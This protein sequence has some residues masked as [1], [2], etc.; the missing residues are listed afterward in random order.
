MLAQLHRHT[1]CQVNHRRLGRAVDHGA[2]ISGQIR[3]NGAVVDDRARRLRFHD[4]RGVLHAEHHGAHKQRHRGVKAFHR[5]ALDAAGRG[6]AAGIVEQHVEPAVAVEHMA[7]GALPVR[8][9]RCVGRHIA[10]VRTQPCRYRV[11][12]WPAP[13]CKD[14]AG[15]F[16]D[17]E[18]RSALADAAGRSGDESDLAVKH[19]HGPILTA[20]DRRAP[21]AK[22][23]RAK[24][25]KPLSGS[26]PM[27]S[28]ILRIEIII[29]HRL[30]CATM[31]LD[32]HDQRPQQCW[33]CDTLSESNPVPIRSCYCR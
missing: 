1:P 2:R 7:H 32:E 25:P 4:G 31:S 11:P 15:A 18:L 10:C 26:Q 30:L 21:P 33:V 22:S 19:S 14:H 8:L 20:G 5:N 16:R 23:C 28:L 24:F 27:R 13:A 3:R 17:E 29:A 12:F 6:R 9:A